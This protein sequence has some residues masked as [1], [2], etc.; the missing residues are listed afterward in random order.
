MSNFVFIAFLQLTILCKTFILPKMVFIAIFR[1]KSL[2]SVV[3]RTE[4]D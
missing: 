3:R 2:A 4:A 1:S